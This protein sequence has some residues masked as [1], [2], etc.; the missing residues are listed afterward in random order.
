VLEKMHAERPGH[1]YQPIEIGKG[2]ERG[3]TEF[4]EDLSFCLRAKALGFPV[5]VHTGVKTTHDKGGV[6]LD[7]DTYDLQQAMRAIA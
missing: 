4:G 3:F 6:F 1:W 7:E 5:Y 2:A